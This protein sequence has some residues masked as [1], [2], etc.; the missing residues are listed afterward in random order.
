MNN[1]IDFILAYVPGMEALANELK[2]SPLIHHLIL[3][4]PE[5]GEAAGLEDER[6]SSI[7]SDN[8]RSTKFL[9]T[10]APKLTAPYTVLYG[11]THDLHLGYRALERMLQ[12][13]QNS[14][15]TPDT[16]LLLYADRYDQNGPH[17]VTDYQDGS[18]R[19][20]FD[21]GSLLFFTTASITSF[22]SQPRT[23]RYRFA[24][25][26]ALRLFISMQGKLIHLPESLYTEAETDLRASGMKQ[27]DYVSP[28]AR[29]VQQEMERA[30]TEHL[31]AIGGW[32]APN[33][34]EELPP[35]ENP[36]N[37]P[38][39]ASVIIPVRNRERTIADAVESALSQQ[40]AFDFN[41]IV[42]DNHSTDGTS[43]VLD[44][45][46]ESPQVIVLHPEQTDLGIG[47]CWD[48]AIRSP[49]C[50]RYAVQLDSDDLYAGPDT[51]TRIVE[52]FT[53]QR[54]AMVVGDVSTGVSRARAWATAAIRI[55]PRP[56]PIGGP[57]GAV[58]HQIGRASC[59]ERV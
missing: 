47:G 26:Y 15:G 59:R 33:E 21:F 28:S 8:L 17:P 53:Q 23:P 24:A 32:L 29:E 49:H 12:A 6:C 30:C 38:V 4:V 20:D 13:A 37:Y 34:L 36:D 43:A 27:F 58:P 55:G 31:K 14:I 44:R 52:T 46:A 41:V 42:I 25:I 7:V 35:L 40:A 19:D 50:G 45:Y 57:A 48:L 3:A 18:L 1:C 56:E 51:L 2:R 39:E 16:P 10:A 9:R 54:A 5:K 22:L 11:S